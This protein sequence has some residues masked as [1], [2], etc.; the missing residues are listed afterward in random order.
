[1]GWT[2]P[3]TAHRRT[4]QPRHLLAD[5]HAQDLSKRER[6]DIY[7]MS[8][9]IER[10]RR[11]GRGRTEEVKREKRESGTL[12]HEGPKAPEKKSRDGSDDPSPG[13]LRGLEPAHSHSSSART[14]SHRR[15][16]RRLIL[17][18]GSFRS[19]RVR[20]A[21]SAEPA[22]PSGHRAEERTPARRQGRSTHWSKGRAREKR[23]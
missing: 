6:D 13:N 18:R 8:E 3:R 2:P 22:S 1:M 12:A 4:P 7:R 16:N 15:H 11:V 21:W 10:R 19:S 17:G 23:C 14:R 5:V 20:H 9:G